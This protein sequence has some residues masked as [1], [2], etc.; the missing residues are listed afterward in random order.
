M[1]TPH[2]RD[3]VPPVAA[4]QRTV[5]TLHGESVVDDYAWMRDRADPRL[6]AYLVEERAY[7]DRHARALEPLID[8]LTAESAA[9]RVTG[10]HTFTWRVGAHEYSIAVPD[11]SRHP[12]YLRRDTRTGLEEIV[13]DL[14]VLGAG[15]DFT[16]IGVFEPSPDGTVLAYSVDHEG[17]ESYELRFRDLRTGQDL[18]QRRA[19]TYYTGAWSADSATFLYVAHDHAMRPYRVL[20]HRLDA[21][22]DTADREVS[23]EDDEHFNTTV[24]TTRD[25]AWIVLSHQSRTTTEELLVPA[26]RTGAAPR[27]VRPREHGR[28]YF[29]EHQSTPSGDRFLLLTASGREERR[30]LAAPAAALAEQRW[31]QLLVSDPEVAWSRLDVF[32]AGLLLSGHRRGT[33][34]FQLVTAGGE[35]REIAPTTPA[36]CLVFEGRRDPTRVQLDHRVAYDSEFIVLTEHSLVDPPRHLRLDLG[37]GRCTV[38]GQDTVDA[39]DRRRY[40]TQRLVAKG[41]DDVEVP[42]TIAHRDDVE[43]D[44]TAACLLYAYGAYERPWEPVFSAPVISLLDRGFVYAV[45]H[46]RGGGELGRRGWFDGSMDAKRNS[47]R[48]LV[49]ARSRLVELG[50]AAPDRMVCQGSCAGG[51]VVCEAYTQQP[52]LWA[53]VVAETPAADILNVMLDAVAPLTV[54]EWEEWGDPRDPRTYRLMREYVAYETVSDRPRPPLYMTAF[55]NDP[56]VMVDRPARWTAALRRVDTHGN[57]IL[58]RT[59]LGAGGHHGS[60]V[61][62]RVARG[63]AELYAFVVDAGGAAARAGRGPA[64]ADAESPR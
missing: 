61:A 5:R 15:R 38:L 53:G 10:A 51:I 19:G 18:P 64:R 34:V 23:R 43:P 45:A 47:H 4:R 27:V 26:D 30:V 14:D 16:R 6:E 41:P 40:R 32:A 36:G 55:F 8:Q 37:T 56:R 58:L 24:R 39:Y 11:G 21:R 22:P 42:V 48:D 50:W 20:A 2:T 63:T 57:R 52:E 35:V 33:M 59:E 62:A 1:D 29:T 49:T 60:T 28:V 17:H 54:N 12:R 31:E 25:R 9:R 7:Y 46:V 3:A 13:L 44:S